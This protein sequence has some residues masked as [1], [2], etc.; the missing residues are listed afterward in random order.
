MCNIVGHSFE[1]CKR[2]KVDDIPHLENDRK[3]KEPKKAY[4]KVD[5]TTFN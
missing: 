4:K 3:N 1:T 5:N 2:I